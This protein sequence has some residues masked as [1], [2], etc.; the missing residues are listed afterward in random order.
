MN[1]KITFKNNNKIIETNNKKYILKRKNQTEEKV[2]NY[3]KNK[4]YEYFLFPET[5]EKNYDLYR[6]TEINLPNQDKAIEL[7]YLMSMLHIKTTT[8]EQINIDKTKE[9]YEETLNHINY[10][11]AY[12]LDLQDYIETKIF[13]S[14][15][16]QVLMFNISKLY[17]ALNYSEQKITA[18]YNEKNNK[19]TDRFVQLHNNLSLSNIIKDE[20][21]YLV[22]WEKS[23]KGI[24]IYDFLN[25]YQNH[26]FELEMNS[27]FKQYQSKF[28]FTPD[29]KYLF[30]ALISIPQKLSFEKDNYINTINAKKV[31]EYIEKT[32]IFLSENYK[33]D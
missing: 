7:I 20:K 5:Y 3:L 30:Q 4:N 28:Q 9:L 16:E 25:F 23:K 17:K 19:K 11:K 32:N 15:A 12:Y 31:I 2:L 27:L 29:E 8:F 13:M 21:S 10:L 1:N 24:P 6:Y 26:Y 18:W 14:P 33:E 22:N